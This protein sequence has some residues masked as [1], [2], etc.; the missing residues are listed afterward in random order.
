MSKVLGQKNTRLFDNMFLTSGLLE[1]C[2][3]SMFLKTEV[4]PHTLQ[5]RLFQKNI[6]FF[7]YF[8]FV[9]VSS[10]AKCQ[11]KIRSSTPPMRNARSKSRMSTPPMQNARSKFRMSTPHMQTARSKSRMQ[12]NG[13]AAA[14]LCLAAAIYIYI[15]VYIVY[16]YVYIYTYIHIYVHIRR[17]LRPRRV[18]ASLFYLTKTF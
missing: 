9:F 18:R 12:I 7:L 4:H 2:V 1:P 8:L 11:V 14:K 6:T 5:L 17:P 15:C 3:L 16:I 10:H 13:L